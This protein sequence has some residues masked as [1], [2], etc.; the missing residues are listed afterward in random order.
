M[1]AAHGITYASDIDRAHIA[2]PLAR[3]YTAD[4]WI[5][6]IDAFSES[7]ERDP[8][9][10][11]GHERRLFLNAKILSKPSTFLNW[12]ERAKPRGNAEDAFVRASDGTIYSPLDA[13]GTRRIVTM[14]A[15]PPGAV[16]RDLE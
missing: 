15:I 11:D 9:T 5:A 14:D 12:L 8:L 6:V 13:D 4:D 3:G 1:R 10:K 16:I 2:G 7:L